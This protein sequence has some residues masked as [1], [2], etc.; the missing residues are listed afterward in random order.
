MWIRLNNF[1]YGK[2]DALANR[3]TLYSCPTDIKISS[4][5]SIGQVYHKELYGGGSASCF[6][7][8]IN[9]HIHCLLYTYS[10]RAESDRAKL[11]NAINNQ[12]GDQVNGPTY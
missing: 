9:G 2:R 11:I 10:S 4:V 8:G 12:L 5:D 6:D 1:N 7:V 3:E